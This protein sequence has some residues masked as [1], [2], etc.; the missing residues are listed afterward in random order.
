M[1]LRKSRL[2]PRFARPLSERSSRARFPEVAHAA[3]PPS[4]VFSGI[5]LF[6]QVSCMDGWPDPLCLVKVVLY[7]KDLK[8]S[9]LL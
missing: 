1:R 6:I 3:L 4:F 8:F 5:F 7:S 2:L 9:F